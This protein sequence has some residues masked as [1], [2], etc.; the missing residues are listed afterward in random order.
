MGVGM[1]GPL[2]LRGRKDESRQ[3]SG[4]LM[5]C[6]RDQEGGK[7]VN[8]MSC[9]DTP[10]NVHNAKPGRSIPQGALEVVLMDPA[11]SG[12]RRGR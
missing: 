10:S 12:C 4:G 8:R 2:P 7:H 1:D 11:N 9:R 3:A 6:L 5:G